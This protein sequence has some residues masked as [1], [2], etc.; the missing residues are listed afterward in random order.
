MTRTMAI[1]LLLAVSVLAGTTP[2]LA[3]PGK[4]SCPLLRDDEGDVQKLPGTESLPDERDAQLDILSADIRADSKQVTVVIRLRDL[5]APDPTDPNGLSYEF[6]F[7]A[8]EQTF[9]V[10][11][12]LV[13]GGN[14]FRVYAQDGQVE[15]QG[16]SARSG[17]AVGSASGTFDLRRHEVRMTAPLS[18]FASKVP[19]TSGTALFDLAAWSWRANGVYVSDPEQFAAVAENADNVLDKKASYRVG[20]PSCSAG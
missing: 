17:T 19:L 15:Q 11:A 5:E 20:Q 12:L 10:T 3:A 9:F 16:S 8:K 7:T 4:V 1:R 2:A 13:T 18:V 6:D 14:A